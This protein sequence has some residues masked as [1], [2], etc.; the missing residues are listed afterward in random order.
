MTA[1]LKAAATG[2]VATPRKSILEWL[3]DPKFKAGLSAVAGKFLTA[4]RMTRLVVNSIN[5]TPRLAECEPRSILGSVMASAA[6]GLEPNTVQQQAF[7]I[8]YKRNVKQGNT[9]TSVYE[10]Q[11][12]IG[13]RGFITLA[14]RSPLILSLA[15]EA[16]HTGDTFEHEQGSKTFLRFVKRIDGQR[17]DLVASWAHVKLQSGAEIVC[18]LP[19]DEL[20]RIRSRSESYR[21]TQAAIDSAG[22]AKARARAEQNFADTPWNLWVDDMAAKSAVKK[23]AKILPLGASDLIMAA[24]NLDDAGETRRVDLSQFTDPDVARGVLLDGYEPPASAAHF[25]DERTEEE[26]PAPA[27]AAPTPTRDPEPVK[28]ATPS[29]AKPAKKPAAPT[30]GDPDLAT[31]TRWMN[32]AKTPDDAAVVLDQARSVAAI[33]PEQFGELAAIRDQRFPAKAD[34]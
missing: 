17:G 5:R 23:L 8:P 12:Q 21:S 31:L 10:C 29:G 15:A 19:F 30:E 20:L 7:L 4:E 11:F 33:T 9:W 28:Q 2:Q 26:S 13:Y 34:K 3:D 16:V 14:Y 1:A 27:A 18:V 24:A 6:L 25:D 32:E 22:D